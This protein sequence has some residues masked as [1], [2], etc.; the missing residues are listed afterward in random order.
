M[1]LAFILEP[2]VCRLTRIGIPRAIASLLAVVLMMTI[3]AGLTY[4]FYNR[5]VDF[6]TQLPKYS[7]KIRTVLGNLRAQSNKIEE[8]T[9]NMIA[10]PKDGKQPIPVQVQEAP[11]LSHVVSESV[12]TLGEVVLAIS[13]VP[14]LVYFMRTLKDHVHLMI[15]RLFPQ[16]HRLVDHPPGSLITAMSGTYSRIVLSV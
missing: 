14:F 5:G 12:S 10:S 1:L 4:F 15:V 16:D 3:V 6:A 7:G 2:L 8:S 13:F 9:R 11:G